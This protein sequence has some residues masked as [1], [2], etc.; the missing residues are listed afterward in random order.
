MKPGA[1]GVGE[2]PEHV[3]WARESADS[4]KTAWKQFRLL[5]G[6]V[7]RLEAALG[8]GRRKE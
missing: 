8:H 6:D 1:G 3:Y 2:V 4:E 7:K 5:L